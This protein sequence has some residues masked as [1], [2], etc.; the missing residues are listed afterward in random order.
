MVLRAVLESVNKICRL[1]SLPGGGPGLKFF[2]NRLDGGVW[3]EEA[4][5]TGFDSSFG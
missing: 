4:T 3:D 2:V 5:A 1:L